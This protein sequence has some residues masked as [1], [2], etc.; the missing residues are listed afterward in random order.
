MNID[1]DTKRFII[2]RLKWLGLYFGIGLI[3]VLL[4]P[5]PM[6]SFLYLLFLYWLTSL[7]VEVFWKDMEELVE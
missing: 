3:L 6:I 1:S 7:E 4:Y 5:F 2:H